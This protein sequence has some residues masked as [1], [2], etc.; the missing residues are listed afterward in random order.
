MAHILLL[1]NLTG[2]RVQENFTYSIFQPCGRAAVC[3]MYVSLWPGSWGSES[4]LASE[5]ADMGSTANI[6]CRGAS[7]GGMHPSNVQRGQWVS[8]TNANYSYT[9]F[10][11]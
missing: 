7:T 11:E 9:V 2:T 3:N 5:V 4:C 1:E 6:C 8:L 10:V